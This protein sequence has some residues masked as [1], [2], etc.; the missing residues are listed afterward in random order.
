[1]KQLVTVILLSFTSIN[2][3]AALRCSNLFKK[4]VSKEISTV[5]VLKLSPSALEA[6][7][8]KS[9]STFLDLQGS[10]LGSVKAKLIS[11]EATTAVN[12]LAYDVN[13]LETAL[14]IVDELPVS[15]FLST[16]VRYTS[17]SGIEKIGSALILKQK[18]FQ[19]V[20]IE[21]EMFHA[22]NLYKMKNDI[23]TNFDGEISPN[24]YKEIIQ[25]EWNHSLRYKRISGEE[26]YGEILAT[27]FR[28][29]YETIPIEEVKTFVVQLSRRTFDPKNSL[30]LLSEAEMGDTLVPT[31]FFV[32][33]FSKHIQKTLEQFESVT[34]T[35][36]DEEIAKRIS[37]K[38]PIFLHPTD[39][40]IIKRKAILYLNDVTY[41]FE[42]IPKNIFDKMIEH[43]KKGEQH[44][45]PE[46][47]LPFAKKKLHDQSKIA[48][49]IENKLDLYLKELGQ[50]RQKNDL[51]KIEADR[52]QKLV[53]DLVK[54]VNF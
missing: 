26:V 54:T 37:I 10:G 49:K 47:F 44:R 46:I 29:A 35:M 43:L 24:S 2:S 21:H 23:P 8:V 39:P 42:N 3:F 30:K 17:P 34:Q 20:I 11:P 15:G 1:M 50:L 16:S 38:N 7:G 31:V 52:L 28:S 18:A 22:E 12:K 4:P 45:I 41:H 27:K 40:S 51:N 48:V 33:N 25:P 6:D 53:S 13:Q 9:S 14:I 32:K 19:G 36:K 5:E